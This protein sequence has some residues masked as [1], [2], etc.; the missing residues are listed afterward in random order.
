MTTSDAR[1]APRPREV[2]WGGLQVVLGSLAALA[3]LLSGAEQLHTTEMRDALAE[4]I[5]TRGAAEAGVSVDTA[6]RVMRYAILVLGAVSAAAT[7]LGVYVLRRHRGSRLAVTIIG[8]VIAALCLLAPPFGWLVGA[9]IATSIGLLWSKAA[10]RWFDPPSGTSSSVPPPPPGSSPPGSSPPTHLP[11]GP[12]TGPPP[13]AQPPPSYGGP[14]M[15][16][17]PPAR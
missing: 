15:P 7:V 13:P 16:P 8:G 12:P 10:R 17:P 6:L 5:R 1:P 11:P 14:P 3:L 9:Y 2:T 4:A